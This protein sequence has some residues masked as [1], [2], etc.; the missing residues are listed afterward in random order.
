MI[1]CDSTGC[2]FYKARGKCSLKKTHIGENGR[3]KDF[4]KGIVYYL[5]LLPSKM[6]KSQFITMPELSDDIRYS[7][8]YLMKCTPLQFAYDDTRGMMIFR[9]SS[10]DKRLL[11][12]NDIWDLISEKLDSEAFRECYDDFEN[13]GLPK[14]TLTEKE[15]KAV[16]KAQETSKE[17]GWVSPLG[18]YTESPWGTYEEYAAKIVESKGW[19]DEYFDWTAHQVNNTQG[20]NFRDFLIR[21][22]NYAL[23]HDPQQL[24]YHVSEPPHLTKKQKDFLYGYFLDMGL[25][26]KAE[27]YLSEDD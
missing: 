6:G 14:A 17:Y 25:R 10:T 23:I 20:I 16:E 12:G 8:Y 7:I 2:R 1:V 24:G 22:K 9:D 18:E 11:S 4:E 15:K 27:K 19:E 5:F 26:L 21:E 13:N 3:C